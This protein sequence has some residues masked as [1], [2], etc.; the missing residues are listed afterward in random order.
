[1]GVVG[2][3]AESSVGGILLHDPPQCHLCSGGH[4]IGFV[5]DDEFEG[6]D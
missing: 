5:E 2:D 4:G 3:Y 1:M 6:G